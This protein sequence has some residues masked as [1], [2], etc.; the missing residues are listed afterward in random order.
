MTWVFIDVPEAEAPM[1]LQAGAKYHRRHQKY[2]FDSRHQDPA[3]FARWSRIPDGPTD[4]GK[5]PHLRLSHRM[6]ARLC[7]ACMR[8]LFYVAF[9]RSS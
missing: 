6:A 8:S 4:G 2:F 1:A 7:S 9:R 5:D 3:R